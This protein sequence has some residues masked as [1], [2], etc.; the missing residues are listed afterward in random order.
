M[1]TKMMIRACL[2]ITGLILILAASG[3]VFAEDGWQ[4]D[5]HVRVLNAENRVVIGQM[6]DA[7]DGI[8]GKYEVPAIL[9]GDIKAFTWTDD[10]TMWKDIKGICGSSC[11]RTWDLMVDSAL[12]GETIEVTWDSR[13]FPADASV[14][15][16]DTETGTSVN[17][18]ENSGY[19]Y[20]NQ[21][22]SQFRIE[23]RIW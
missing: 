18:L 19:R 1:M 5:I 22:A 21:G 9:A 23:V 14:T 10:K 13:S 15:L 6:P 11:V 7:T 17:M 2:V 3:A 8:D 20:T 4:A 16:V 12:E